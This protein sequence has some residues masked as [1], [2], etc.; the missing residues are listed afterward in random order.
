MRISPEQDLIACFLAGKPDAVRT[1]DEWIAKAAYTYKNR[2]AHVWEDVLQSA[3]LEVTRLLQNGK[4]RAESSL[5]TY[6][7]RVVNST[8][9]NFIRQQTRGEFVE[10]DFEKPDE[11]S[12]SP[13]DA[14]L[15]K[16]SETMAMRVWAEMSDDCRSLWRMILR[17][18]SYDEMSREVKISSGTLRVRVLRCREKAVNVREKIF[19]KTAN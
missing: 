15:Q 7:W 6:L 2:L 12:V 8:C 4:F 10:I 18:M 5:K 16:E 17:G 3:R 1:I 11:I 9:L 14:V 13:I 19:R